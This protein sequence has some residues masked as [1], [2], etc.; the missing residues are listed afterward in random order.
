MTVSLTS[1]IEQ[2]FV[3]E[4][5]HQ[6]SINQLYEETKDTFPDRDET[7]MRHSIRRSIQSLSSRGFIVRTAPANYIMKEN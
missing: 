7:K 6:L 5:S 2:L 1:L 4:K 3:K